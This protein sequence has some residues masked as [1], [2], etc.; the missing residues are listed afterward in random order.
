M[1]LILVVYWHKY[2]FCGV[3]QKLAPK[4]GI[5]CVQKQFKTP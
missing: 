3:S 1:T 4:R 2:K 5:F